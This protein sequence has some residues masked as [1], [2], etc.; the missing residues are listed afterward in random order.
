MPKVALR[1]SGEVADSIG[2]DW[3]PVDRARAYFATAVAMQD[4]RNVVFWS[5]SEVAGAGQELLNYLTGSSI[6]K[7]LKQKVLLPPGTIHCAIP[8]GIFKP[9]GASQAGG[10]GMLT[11]IA[12]G[13]ETHLA[14]PPR[15][16]DPKQ[17]WN[18][19]WSV[20]VRTKST[21]MAMLGVDLSGMQEMDTGDM[22][23]S[24]QQD[25][26]KPEEGKGKKLLKGLL[27]NL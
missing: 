26:P 25:Q 1:T 5:S 16:A 20:R 14:W 9:T 4:E 21:S 11:F 12:Y 17:P 13:P 19:E 24:Q 22:P 23:A 18:P 15:P 6:D 7:W 3:Q 8:Q 27:R 2:V 10:M